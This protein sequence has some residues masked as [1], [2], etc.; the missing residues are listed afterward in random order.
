[1]AIMNSFQHFPFLCNRFTIVHVTEI[2]A[3]IVNL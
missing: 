1:M 2:V 3:T